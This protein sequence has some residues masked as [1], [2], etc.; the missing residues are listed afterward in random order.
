VRRHPPPRDHPLSADALPNLPVGT[1]ISRAATTAAL[2]LLIAIWGTTWAAIRIGLDG[3]PPLTGVALRFALASAVLFALV[4]VFRVRL[5]RSRREVGLWFVNAAFTFSASYGIVYWAEQRVP[6]G[7][8]AVLFATFPLFV[9]GFG[10]FALPAERLTWSSAV[11]A[12]VGFAGVAVIF[13]E[14]LSRLAGPGVGRAAAILLLSP[15]LSA[16]ANVAVKRWGAGIHP[17]SL[18]AVPMA[19][20]AVFMGG[21]S[22][23]VE[24]GRPIVWTPPAVASLLYLAI[25]GSAVTFT[26]YYRLLALLPAT[27]LS[28]ITYAVPVVAVAIGTLAMGEPITA[29]ILAGAALVVAGVVL[30]VRLRPRPL[31]EVRQER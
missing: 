27:R 30:A 31:A 17:L 28:L 21:L 25:F 18:T 13:S 22:A 7:L 24:A 12:L 5:G 3:I 10:H 9:A 1:P 11:G 15:L 6:S 16:V 26:V 4:P 8:V 19:M 2:A 20:T 23:I 29:R 14:D